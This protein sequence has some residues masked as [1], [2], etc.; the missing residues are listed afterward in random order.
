M[1]DSW[2]LYFHIVTEK[3]KDVSGKKRQKIQTIVLHQITQNFCNSSLG[4][5]DHLRNGKFPIKVVLN[6]LC[7]ISPMQDRNP[8][9]TSYSGWWTFYSIH[10]PK[11]F[12]LMQKNLEATTAVCEWTHQCRP[13]C[14]SMWLLFISH[15][16]C[17]AARQHPSVSMGACVILTL[18]I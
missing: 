15:A 7:C 3:L 10:Q 6:S 11:W 14:N 8:K 17:V 9:S 5:T 18:L 4:P 13:Y 12:L 16:V 2:T 1:L